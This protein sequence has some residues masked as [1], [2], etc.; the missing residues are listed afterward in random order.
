MGAG[1]HPSQCNGILVVL[2][3]ISQYCVR[4]AR[5]GGPCARAL[6]VI[7]SGEISVRPCRGSFKVPVTSQVRSN[8]LLE[9]ILAKQ[10]TLEMTVSRLEVEKAMLSTATAALAKQQRE[11]D[12]QK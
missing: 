6:R 9:E 10:D 2:R 5:Q 8:A 3:L 7:A 4:L 11:K 12:T 1:T